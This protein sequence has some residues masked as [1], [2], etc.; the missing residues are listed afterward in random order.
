M[1]RK[2]KLSL[3]LVPSLSQWRRRQEFHVQ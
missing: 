3:A 1:S 2:F